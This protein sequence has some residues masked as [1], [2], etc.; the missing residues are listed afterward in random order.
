MNR[1]CAFSEVE[2]RISGMNRGVELSVHRR[3]RCW[4]SQVVEGFGGVISV[5][6]GASGNGS[7][8]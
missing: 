1:G 5:V 8:A 4:L 3:S 2:R 7:P 6:V